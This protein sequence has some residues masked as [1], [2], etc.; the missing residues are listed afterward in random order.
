VWLVRQTVK[1]FLIIVKADLNNS[2]EQWT[3]CA[4]LSDLAA[5]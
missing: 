3:E 4:A 5:G 1:P 2:E